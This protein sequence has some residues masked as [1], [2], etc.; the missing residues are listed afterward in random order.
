MISSAAADRAL[1]PAPVRSAAARITPSLLAQRG[2]LHESQGYP[3]L[4]SAAP[5]ALPTVDDGGTFGGRPP[6]PRDFGGLGRYQDAVREIPAR[7][8]IPSPLPLTQFARFVDEREAQY[9]VEW[10]GLGQATQLLPRAA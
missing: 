7:Y 8:P 2:T 5:S 6:H 9:E 4:V 1:A 3:L 10:R